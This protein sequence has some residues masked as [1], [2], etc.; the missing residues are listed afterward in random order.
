MARVEGT[1]KG[2]TSIDHKAIMEVLEIIGRRSATF[3]RSQIASQLGTLL[4]DERRYIISFA[5]AHETLET[6]R[7][8]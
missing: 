8:L 6:K 7:L 4:T 1:A 3:I 5:R 2:T